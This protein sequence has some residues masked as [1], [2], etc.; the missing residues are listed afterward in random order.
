MGG[1][2]QLRSGKRHI[3]ERTG[4]MTNDAGNSGS[5][6]ERSSGWGGDETVRDHAQDPSRETGWDS[7]RVVRDH[8]QDEEHDD[9]AG[10]SADKVVRD[11]GENPEPEPDTG[12]SGTQVAKDEGA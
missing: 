1:K 5:T 4:D 11:R 7:E 9:S 6:A 12:W 10:W 8:E 2:C 3:D